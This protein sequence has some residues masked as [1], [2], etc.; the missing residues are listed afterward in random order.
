[1]SYYQN[2]VSVQVFTAGPDFWGVSNQLGFVYEVGGADYFPVRTTNG[3]IIQFKRTEVSFGEQNEV[4]YY[5]LPKQYSEVVPSGGREVYP[6]AWGGVRGYLVNGGVNIGGVPLLFYAVMPQWRPDDTPNLILLKLH[7]IGCELLIYPYAGGVGY[8]LKSPTGTAL[9]YSK[10]PHSVSRAEWGSLVFSFFVDYKVIFS[11]G[12]KWLWLRVGVNDSIDEFCIPSPTISLYMSGDV[13]LIGYG[14]FRFFSALYDVSPFTLF[15]LTYP[16]NMAPHEILWVVDNAGDLAYHYDTYFP[17]RSNNKIGVTLR[18]CIVYH[19]PNITH[20]GTFA[21][22]E[23]GIEEL[24]WSTEGGRLVVKGDTNIGIGNAVKIVVSD[25][26][27]LYRAKSTEV[28]YSGDAINYT[29]KTIELE[30]PLLTN[31]HTVPIEFNPYLLRVSDIIKAMRCCIHLNF[32]IVYSS[33][34]NDD[35]VV[36]LNDRFALNSPQ[37]WADMLIKIAGKEDG[38]RWWVW[39]NTIYLQTPQQAITF[40]PPPASQVISYRFVADTSMPTVG[41]IGNKIVVSPDATNRGVSIRTGGYP[42]RY[43]EIWKVK[44][45]FALPEGGYVAY[46]NK[47]AEVAKVSWRITAPHEAETDIEL[48]VIW[49]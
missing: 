40:N 1:M 31:Y 35:D 39:G 19:N 8:S 4:F 25:T 43:R 9:A 17:E 44:G 12:G 20:A 11:R 48:E 21:N 5:Q 38:A 24:S 23:S 28:E 32:N 10:Q 13:T 42:V 14:A 2:P 45:L 36:L 26:E 7:D 27:F 41:V 18:R 49:V 46:A 6:P 16:I 37:D 22:A 3:D 47:V 29:T 15:N 33:V 30:N 34:L